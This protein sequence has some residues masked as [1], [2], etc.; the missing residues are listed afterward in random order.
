MQ[1]ARSVYIKKYICYLSRQMFLLIFICQTPKAKTE[2]FAG[3]KNSR[4]WE[5]HWASKIMDK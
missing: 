4:F 2:R 1:T 5:T 3:Q